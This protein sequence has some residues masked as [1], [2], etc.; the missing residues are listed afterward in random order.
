MKKKRKIANF[1]LEEK[2][3]PVQSSKIIGGQTDDGGLCIIDNL[4]GRVHEE[5]GGI[6]IQIVIDSC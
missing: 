1:Q 6:G 3:L 2:L 5:D 4:S